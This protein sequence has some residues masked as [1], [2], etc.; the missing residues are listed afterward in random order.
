MCPECARPA[1]RRRSCQAAKA[2]SRQRQ[3]MARC[4]TATWQ[5]PAQPPRPSAPSE[6]WTDAAAHSVARLAPKFPPTGYRAATSSAARPERPRPAVFRQRPCQCRSF[7]R[8]ARSLT[9]MPYL[10]H[11]AGPADLPACQRRT[12]ARKTVDKL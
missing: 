3:V 2:S 11:E 6:P 12:S 4:Q 5:P 7:R 8:T 1:Y 10:L 9:V